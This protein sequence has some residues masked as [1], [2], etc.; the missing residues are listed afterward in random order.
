MKKS[1]L[2]YGAVADGKTINTDAIQRTIDEVAESGGGMV[3]IPSGTFLRGGITLRSR[4][5][6]FL[7]AGGVLK[8][9]RDISLFPGI[10]H[11]E[12]FEQKKAAIASQGKAVYGRE[13]QICFDNSYNAFI[14]AENQTDITIAGFGTI[15][16]DYDEPINWDV[17][18]ADRVWPVCFKKCRRIHIRDISLV[19]SEFW[20]VTMILCSDVQLR[21]LTIRNCRE[22]ITTDGIDLISSKRVII[23]DCNIDVGDDAIATHDHFG[24][25]TEDVVITN[26]LLRTT[27]CALRLCVESVNYQRNIMVSNCITDAPRCICFDMCDGGVFE[28]VR[29]MN[30]HAKNADAG[31]EMYIHP[32]YGKEEEKGTIRDITIDGLCVVGKGRIYIA[33]LPDRPVKNLVLR[34]IYWRLPN[35]EKPFEFKPHGGSDQKRSPLPFE[36][37]YEK[38]P[39]HIRIVCADDVVLDNICI[40]DED[41]PTRDRDLLCTTEVEHLVTNNVRWGNERV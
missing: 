21:G 33:G 24:H 32:R 37:R 2:E 35:D 17:F 28:N 1:I 36:G 25:G 16:G 14:S 9:S 20:T 30:I 3:V 7:E 15:D 27:C 5:T 40:E 38:E 18:T 29:F 31:V 11:K 26:C 10:S 39:Y 4:V 8:A 34:N 13:E 41:V 22:R 23:S 6:L 19:N 12:F